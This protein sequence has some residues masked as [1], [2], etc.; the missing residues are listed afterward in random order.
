MAQRAAVE[1]SQ[2]S[3]TYS[4]L[5]HMQKRFSEQGVTITPMEKQL[6]E[7]SEQKSLYRDILGMIGNI[8]ID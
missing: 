7:L 8:L 3:D 2:L 5:K 6:D 4:N 1:I